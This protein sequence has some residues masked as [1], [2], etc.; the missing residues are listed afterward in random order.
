MHGVQAE[1]AV[2]QAFIPNTGPWRPY[3]ADHDVDNAATAA[4]AGA[5]PED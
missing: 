4:R 3:F 2:M 1:R 5:P